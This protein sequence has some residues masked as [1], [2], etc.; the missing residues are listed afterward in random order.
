MLPQK[1]QRQSQFELTEE[2]EQRKVTDLSPYVELSLKQRIIR[3]L[4]CCVFVLKG[5]G[6]EPPKYMDQTYGEE[7]VE[8]TGSGGEIS[9]KLIEPKLICNVESVR[10]MVGE[11]ILCIP[12]RQF[13]SQYVDSPWVIYFLKPVSGGHPLALPIYR[14]ATVEKDVVR[15]FFFCLQSLGFPFNRYHTRPRLHEH[16]QNMRLRLTDGSQVVD[17]IEHHLLKENI[18]E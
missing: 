1:Y 13:L 10:V 17:Y 14:T 12:T 9:A 11:T 7:F 16:L 18:P 2:E 8:V 6:Y 3:G 5:L 15:G 4:N